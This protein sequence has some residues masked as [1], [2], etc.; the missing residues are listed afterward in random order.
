MS[1]AQNQT[2]FPTYEAADSRPDMDMKTPG[3]HYLDLVSPGMSLRDFFAAFA[4]A[5]F[6]AHAAKISNIDDTVGS[7]FQYA[8]AMLRCRRGA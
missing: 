7:A 4:L 6:L 8:D 1:D 3:E 5:G 2:A